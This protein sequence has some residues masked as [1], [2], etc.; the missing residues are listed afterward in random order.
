MDNKYSSTLSLNDLQLEVN[1]GAGK[2]ERSVKQNILV[3]FKIFFPKKPKACDNDNVEDTI[4][5]FKLSQIIEDY[6]R[7]REFHLLEYL[8]VRL[9]EQLRS[10][11]KESAR[12]WVRVDK[13][14]PP[15]ENIK[16]TTSFEYSDL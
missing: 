2:Q 11:M 1:L 8:C 9:H 6:C 4:C 15:I 16:G 3:S 13:C 5:Y 14:K 12:L 10:N 7:N